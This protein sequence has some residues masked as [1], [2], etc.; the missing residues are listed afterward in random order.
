MSTAEEFESSSSNKY[1]QALCCCL[2]V[3]PE[4]GAIL[5]FIPLLCKGLGFPLGGVVTLSKRANF[6][7]ELKSAWTTFKAY[8]REKLRCVFPGFSSCRT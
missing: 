5:S 8:V 2:S 7:M 1:L 4:L 3:L 6:S